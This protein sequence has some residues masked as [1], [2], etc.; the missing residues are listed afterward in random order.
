AELALDAALRQLLERERDG[1]L[2]VLARNLEIAP[3][4]A[5]A[6]PASAE[7]LEQV[8]QVDAAEV[9]FLLSAAAAPKA[10]E[11]VRRR[12]KVLSRAVAAEAVVGGA[13]LLVLQRLVGLGH[14]LELLLG[15]RLLGDVR[16]VLARELAVGLLDLVVGG[17]ALDTEGL[18]VVL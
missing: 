8:R 12:P 4:E 15:V 5:A 18:V 7:R 16:V 2:V 10:A 17:A 14:L 6:E 9:G 11:P 13:L 1:H 3:A